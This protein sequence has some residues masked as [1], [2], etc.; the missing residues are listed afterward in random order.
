MSDKHRCDNCEGN[1]FN[2]GDTGT[3]YKKECPSCDGT[4]YKSDRQI[5]ME[6][7]LKVEETKEENII[8]KS[9]MDKIRKIIEE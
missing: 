1:G 6:E 7:I 2:F 8:L 9:K 3:Y 4:G 5:K